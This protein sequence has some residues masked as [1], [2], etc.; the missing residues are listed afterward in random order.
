MREY[1]REYKLAAQ[2]LEILASIRALNDNQKKLEDLQQQLSCFEASKIDP[3]LQLPAIRHGDRSADALAELKNQMSALESPFFKTLCEKLEIKNANVIF[4]ETIQKYSSTASS[5]GREALK[6]SFSNQSD[7]EQYLRYL[8]VCKQHFSTYA[9]LIFQSAQTQDVET[10]R[11]TLAE[12]KKAC[13]NEKDVLK[14]S[15]SQNPMSWIENTLFDPADPSL[16]EYLYGD[17]VNS[18]KKEISRNEV[19]DHFAENCASEKR[20]IEDAIAQCREKQRECERL[21]EELKRFDDAYFNHPNITSVIP[22]DSLW[23]LGVDARDHQYGRLVYDNK[24]H[25]RGTLLDAEP[26]YVDGMETALAFVLRSTGNELTPDFIGQVRRIACYFEYLYFDRISDA[27]GPPDMSNTNYY[28]DFHGD[29]PISSTASSEE[30]IKE[31]I[32][33]QVWNVDNEQEFLERLKKDNK[34]HVSGIIG[35]DNPGRDHMA[36]YIQQYHQWMVEAGDDNNKKLLA[37]AKFCRLID[38][39]HPFKDGNIRTVRLLMLKLMIENNLVP[40]MMMDPNMLD[41][42]HSSEIVRAMKEGQHVYEAA[43]NR[44]LTSTPQTLFGERIKEAAPTS[45]PPTQ[46]DQHITQK[47]PGETP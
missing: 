39:S 47:K 42:Y 18:K 2:R 12:F 4:S 36:N 16:L 10:Y 28:P 31:M 19:L 37:I 30:G 1:E 13:A 21:Q 22:R 34:I 6:A 23:K 15:I 43:C 14:Q 17:V 11:Q 46:V 20:K 9:K 32:R 45:E 44:T 41:G 25:G 7:K 24:L 3:L 26:G 5:V 8:D 35:K 29:F 33:L 40:T 27:F 38:C